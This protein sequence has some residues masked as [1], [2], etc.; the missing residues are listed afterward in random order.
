M[1][2]VVLAQRS[3]ERNANPHQPP[4]TRITRND[5]KGDIQFVGSGSRANSNKEKRKPTPPTTNNNRHKTSKKG[6]PN[7]R[8]VVFAQRSPKRNANPYQPLQT[9]ITTKQPKKRIP[10]LRRATFLPRL[11]WHADVPKGSLM[12]CGRPWDPS[13]GSGWLLDAVGVTT[14]EPWWVLGGSRKLSG[15]S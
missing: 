2:G 15:G 6:I 1:R 10:N 12:S 3:S 11:W 14:V 7:L 9:R 8:G 4:Q 5:Q 13:G